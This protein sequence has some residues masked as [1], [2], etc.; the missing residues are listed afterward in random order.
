MAVLQA[1][2]VTLYDLTQHFGLQAS[3]DGDF[4]PEWQENLPPITPQEAQQLARIKANYLHLV[5]RSLL[6]DLVKMVV[7]SPLLDL[8]GF[9]LPPFY[10]TTEPSVTVTLADQ[11]L[12]LRG[13]LDI[14]V[15]QDQLWVLAIESKRASFSLEVGMPQI[16]AYL[17]AAPVQERPLFGCVTNGGHFIFVKLIRDAQ[18]P[19][20]QF[21]DEFSLRRDRDLDQILAIIKGLAQRFQPQTERGKSPPQRGGMA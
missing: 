20:Y 17:L 7:V 15:L 8:A 1:E 13:R 14:L 18:G 9:Y 21:S 3:S 19:W 4:F 6:E 11:D 2:Q 16:L 12:T 10:T 5:M